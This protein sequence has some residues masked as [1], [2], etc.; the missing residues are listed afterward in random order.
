MTVDLT[1]TIIW[2]DPR[3][4]CAAQAATVNRTALDLASRVLRDTMSVASAYYR[5]TR[6]QWI[7]Q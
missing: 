1:L 6:R 7:L 5:E 2:S 3:T 4:P